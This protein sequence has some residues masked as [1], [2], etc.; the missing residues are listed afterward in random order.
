LIGEGLSTDSQRLSSERTASQLSLS[1]D[2]GSELESEA[3]DRGG[4]VFTFEDHMWDRLPDI[5]A[6]LQRRS[7]MLHEFHLF[8]KTFNQSLTRFATDVNKAQD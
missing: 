2:K 4:E 5:E 8:C 1:E 3:R 7:K 6:H